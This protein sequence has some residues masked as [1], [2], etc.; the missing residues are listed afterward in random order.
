VT[1]KMLSFAERGRM[2]G[3]A[4]RRSLTP[5]ERQKAARKAALARWQN[6]T[7]EQRREIARKTVLARWMRGKGH[8]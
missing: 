2:G 7:K 3:R 4:T 8:A 5:E 1:K 6:T